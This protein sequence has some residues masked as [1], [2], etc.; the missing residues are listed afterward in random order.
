MKTRLYILEFTV[1]ICQVCRMSSRKERQG[2]TKPQKR[3][4]QE[5]TPLEKIEQQQALLHIEQLL[6]EQPQQPQLQLTH[7][8]I[9]FPD[10]VQ[11]VTPRDAISDPDNENDINA[12]RAYTDRIAHRLDQVQ[13]SVNELLALI[14]PRSAHATA[15]DIVLLSPCKSVDQ[16]EELDQS[17]NQL[18][19]R[20]KMQ[21][22]LVTLGG[23]N[24]GIA[25]RRMLRRVATNDVLSQ[26]SLRGRKS[27]RAFQDLSLCRIIIGAC[28]ISFPSLT[29]A[30]VEDLIGQALKFAPHRQRSSRKD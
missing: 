5:F 13:D 30:Q 14:P 15:D 10:P 21:H 24:G 4:K 23:E 29:A 12:L 8:A 22:Y 1:D 2:Y 26:Y 3:I 9:P 27:K 28:Q 7:G 19:R 11:E 17:L 18:E 20:T 6:Q 16:L 25:V